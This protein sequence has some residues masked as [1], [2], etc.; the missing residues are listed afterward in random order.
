MK[1]IG[2]D[3]DNTIVCY[4]RLFHRLAVERGLVPADTPALKSAVR[5]YLRHAGAEDLWTELQGE[6]YG[7]RMVE[8]EPFPG[9]L[10]FFTRCRAH[11]H[12]V[13]I[14]SHRS[15]FPYAG[16]RYDL[17]Q[18]AR[19]WLEGR[20]FYDPGITLPRQCVW[21]E[22][23]KQAKLARIAAAGCTHFIDDLPEFLA[24][25]AFPPGVQKILFDPSGQVETCPGAGRA[26]SWDAIGT[27]LGEVR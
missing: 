3:L 8:A 22:L 6:V 20:F 24:E 11:G 15:Q 27:L 18:A 14:I 12:A 10:E 13:C 21:L 19:D 16:P 1:I 9:A 23:S 26:E 25:P 17:H 2:V 5:D 4:D 7:S